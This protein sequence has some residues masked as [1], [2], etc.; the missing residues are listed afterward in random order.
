MALRLALIADHYRADRAWTDELRKAAEQRLGR[1]RAAVAAP[2][3]PDGAALL[4]GLRARL[5]DDLDTPGALALVDEW[6]DAAIAGRRDDPDA[7]ALVRAGV[8]ALLG[9]RL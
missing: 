1:W 3:G 5:A 6:A 4:A 2:A 9:V 8:D 7:P